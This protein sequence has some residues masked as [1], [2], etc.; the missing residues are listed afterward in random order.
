M[1]S[2]KIMSLINQFIPVG[3]AVK[4]L[5]KIDPR[6]KSFIGAAGAF[7]Y[8]ANEI[9][10]YLRSKTHTASQQANRQ[11]LEESVARGTARPDEA[12]NLERLNQSE[13][14]G[15]ILQSA[16]ALGAGALG[17]L[18]AAGRVPQAAAQMAQ[19]PA[20]QGAAK[21][22]QAVG[23]I[24]GPMAQMQGAST[25]VMSGRAIQSA[26][27]ALGTLAQNRAQPQNPFDMF[28]RENPELGRFIEKKAN[29]G[30]YPTD[31][32]K[33][34][35]AVIKFKTPIQKIEKRLGQKFE[36]VVGQI[37]GAGEQQQAGP[38]QA[39]SALLEAI[40]QTKSL[41]GGR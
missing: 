35:K 19:S 30:I 25:P 4:G 10:S 24:G 12:A 3:L 34:A 23:Q 18:G 40:N 8:G 27:S 37:F 5:E 6:M 7:G 29:E 22:Q 39:K 32:A 2:N 41:L 16:G 31:A 1:F 28:K 11:N 33:R 21:V 17:G 38:S 14:P 20:Q 15:D 26:K 36:D 9:I 13:I